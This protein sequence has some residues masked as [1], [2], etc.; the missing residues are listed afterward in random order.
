MDPLSVATSLIAT[1]SQL[2]TTISLLNDIQNKSE[3][4]RKL[5]L[6]LSALSG[7]LQSLRS[8]GE[9]R[10]EEAHWPK[11]WRSLL[12]SNG[13]ISELQSALEIFTRSLSSARDLGQT[14][15]A[16]TW[17]RRSTRIQEVRDV[18]ERARSVIA[19]ALTVESL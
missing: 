2:T 10:Q 3:D 17:A 13:P 15:I 16:W 4:V 6:E 11:L 1:V 14:K 18:V 5:I 19:L 9:K 7:L 8:L 12:S